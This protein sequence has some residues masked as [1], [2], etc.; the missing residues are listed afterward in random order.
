MAN[1][2]IG[3]TTQRTTLVSTDKF[4]IERGGALNHID[5]SDI[6]TTVQAL[7]DTS[8]NLDRFKISVRAASLANVS[9]ASAPATLDGVTLAA[10]D[11]ILL[12][13]QTA[14]AENGIYV[15]TAAA[16]ALTRSLDADTSVEA[17]STMVVAIE[18]G[19]VHKDSLWALTTNNPITLGTTALVFEQFSY[20]NIPTDTYANWAARKTA[21][22]LPRGWIFISD[23][24]V[25]LFCIASNGVSNSGYYLAGGIY[26]DCIYDFTA[27]IVYQVSDIKANIFC[28]NNGQTDVLLN[29]NGIVNN[30]FFDTNGNVVMTGFL[31][32]CVD[33]F[34]DSCGSGINIANGAATANIQANQIRLGTIVTATGAGSIINNDFAGIEGVTAIVNNGVSINGCKFYAK[35]AITLDPSVSYSGKEI[36][37]GYSNFDKSYDIT[38]L[39]TLTFHATYGNIIGIANLTATPANETINLFANFPTNHPVL[40]KPESG[41]TV[42]FTHATGANQPRC[43]GGINLVLNGTNG[44]WAYFVKMADGFIYQSYTYTG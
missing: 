2:R 21:S 24:S 30:K 12:K 10:N 23:K 14:G 15:F 4:P 5:Y 16:A 44:D 37:S 27:D 33:N 22:T 11:R 20:A 40:I 42:T 17:K 38:A 43:E 19:D 34:I 39:T 31:G 32:S 26:M 25:Y 6:E 35:L 1:K 29:T 7:I 8:I 3:Q 41:L 18:E 28:G 9:L 36:R 13:N